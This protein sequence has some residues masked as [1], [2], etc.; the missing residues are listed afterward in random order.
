M[1]AGWCQSA[2]FPYRNILWSLFNKQKRS[3]AKCWMMP[4]VTRNNLVWV[5][6]FQN[7]PYSL[8]LKGESLGQQGVNC[9]T[10]IGFCHW[11]LNG[12]I[13]QWLEAFGNTVCRTNCCSGS[14]W[15]PATLMCRGSVSRS[16]FPETSRLPSLFEG[17][18]AMMSRMGQCG[19][20]PNGDVLEW[21]VHSSCGYLSRPDRFTCFLLMWW[22]LPTVSMCLTGPLSCSHTAPNKKF[23]TVRKDLSSVCLSACSRGVIHT[24]KMELIILYYVLS[25]PWIYH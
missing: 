2:S 8:Q 19:G 3:I 23:L 21:M 14:V 12:L 15:P 22:S 10:H 7:S 24:V 9:I 17:P 5:Q 13:L 4:G 16:T 18:K 6:I 11:H 25:S 1:L 20:P